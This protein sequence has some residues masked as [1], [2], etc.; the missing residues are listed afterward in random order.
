EQV[1]GL[2]VSADFFPL[3]GVRPLA[4]RW[5][6][7]QDDRPGAPPRLILSFGFW[8]RRFGGDPQ[9]IG[10]RLNIFG[11][12][13][14]VIGVMPSGFVLPDIR[15]EVFFAAQIDPASAPT[16]GRNFQVYGRMRAGIKIAAAQAEMRSLAAQTAAERPETNARWSA[17]AIPLLD[18]AVGDV[19]TS[20]LV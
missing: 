14:E 8:Q 10:S 5:L 13:G 12:P 2:R 19:R 4:G 9:I 6:T 17:T 20:L 16:D 18:D 15:P 1:N 11:Q 3:L 7:P